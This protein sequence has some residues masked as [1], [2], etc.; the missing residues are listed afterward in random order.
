MGVLDHAERLESL[1][2]IR[3]RQAALQ[4]AAKRSATAPMEAFRQTEERLLKNKQTE[5][6]GP[7]DAAEGFTQAITHRKSL[8]DARPVT[9]D[10]K[11]K[12]VKKDASHADWHA[13]TSGGLRKS[14]FQRTKV[15]WATNMSGLAARR[16]CCVSFFGAH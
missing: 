5:D 14:A 4:D 6:W 9:P 2:R 13:R 3:R 16:R 7:V 15:S 8:R 1:D 10:L 11:P 12:T